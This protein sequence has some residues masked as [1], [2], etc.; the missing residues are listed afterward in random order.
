MLKGILFFVLMLQVVNS[1]APTA[2][3]SSVV[4]KLFMS[5]VSTPVSYK[6]GFMFPGQGGE[7][8][9]NSLLF[10][11]SSTDDFFS[12]LMISSTNCGHGKGSHRKSSS[13]KSIIRQSFRDIRIRFIIQ[14]MSRSVC[15]LISL[16]FPFPSVLMDQKKN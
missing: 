8:S 14:G 15:V 16:S 2:V 12:E 5:S 10:V 13:S 1:F 4:R 9:C 3:K 11:T 7:Y 6:V